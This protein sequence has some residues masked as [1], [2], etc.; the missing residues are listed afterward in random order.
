MPSMLSGPEITVSN[1][2]GLIFKLYTE[3]LKNMV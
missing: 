3:K 1:F 2:P